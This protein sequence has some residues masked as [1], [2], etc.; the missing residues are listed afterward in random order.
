MASYMLVRHKVKDFTE[1]KRGYDAHLPARVAA[2][3]TEKHLLRGSGD[4]NDVAVL[5]EAQDLDRATTFAASAE[6]R[7]KMQ[8]VGVLGRPDISFLND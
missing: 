3:L 7:D 1:W 2:G 4:S 6:L 8:E 5:F